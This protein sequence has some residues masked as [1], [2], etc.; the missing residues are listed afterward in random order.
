MYSRVYGHRRG[1]LFV[2]SRIATWLYNKNE[3]DSPTL[4]V[5][6]K[7]LS[8]KSQKSSRSST[9]SLNNSKKSDTPFDF[10]LLRAATIQIGN[11][12]ITEDGAY[13]SRLSYIIPL[14]LCR[15][16]KCLSFFLLPI[17]FALTYLLECIRFGVSFFTGWGGG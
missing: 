6:N 10:S 4:L 12:Y 15:F 7:R 13:S 11:S 8:S 5:N 1:Y 3:M 17:F 2:A 14:F 9:S 16:H